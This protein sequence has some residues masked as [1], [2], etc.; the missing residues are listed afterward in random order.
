MLVCTIYDRIYNDLIKLI[1]GEINKVV[2]SQYEI[3][4]L[5]KKTYIVGKNYK[6]ARFSKCAVVLS[7]LVIKNGISQTIDINTGDYIFTKGKF[8]GVM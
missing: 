1:K 2:V 4:E 7:E 8:G 5:Y 6:T 3:N